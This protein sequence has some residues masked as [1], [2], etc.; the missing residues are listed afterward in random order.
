MSQWLGLGA[1]AV[2]ARVPF[3]VGELRSCKPCSVAKTENN[4]I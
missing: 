1:L 3:L 2:V 4:V